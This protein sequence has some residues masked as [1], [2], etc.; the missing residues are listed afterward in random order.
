MGAGVYFSLPNKLLCPKGRGI[1]H[2]GWVQGGAAGLG[3]Q[4]EAVPHGIA[5]GPG[6]LQVVDP[7]RLRHEGREDKG[8]QQG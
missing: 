1:F 5:P 2:E 3:R 8:Q 4:E 7:Q 6:Y